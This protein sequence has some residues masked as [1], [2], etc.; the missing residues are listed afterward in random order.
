MQEYGLLEDGERSYDGLFSGLQIP[1]KLI[2]CMY[3][4]SHHLL[5]VHRLCVEIIGKVDGLHAFKGD[6]PPMGRQCM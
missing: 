4:L 5:K 6:F 3:M 2:A 1:S